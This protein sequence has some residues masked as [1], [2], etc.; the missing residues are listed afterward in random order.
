MSKHTSV[1]NIGTRCPPCCFCTSLYL[2]VCG[3]IGG[4]DQVRLF[5]R[6]ECRDEAEAFAVGFVR[7][8]GQVTEQLDAGIHTH[9]QIHRPHNPGI[10]FFV[11]GK[12]A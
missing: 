6:V 10:R 11:L 9:I 3:V 5:G 2:C 4:S 1:R 8:V 7:R 12:V